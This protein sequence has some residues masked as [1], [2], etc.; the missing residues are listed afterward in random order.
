MT[1]TN[2][3]KEVLDGR[4]MEDLKVLNWKEII[5]LI[6]KK[7]LINLMEQEYLDDLDPM[8]GGS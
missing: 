8:E 7:Q 6:L 5:M 4:K 2:L 3:V 1:K